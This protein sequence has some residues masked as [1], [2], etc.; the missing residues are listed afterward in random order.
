LQQKRDEITIN[1]DSPMPK[2]HF[3]C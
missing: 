3:W 1:E 2:S